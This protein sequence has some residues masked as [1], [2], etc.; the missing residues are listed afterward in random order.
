[1]HGRSNTFAKSSSIRLRKQMTD[2]ER[3]LWYGLRHKQLGVKFRR[4]HA[5]DNYILDFVCLEHKLV[6]EVDGSQHVENVVSDCAR[7]EALQRAGFR[8]LRFF[9][10]EALTTTEAV[11]EKILAELNPPPPQP[12][13]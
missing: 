6:V 8:V 7:T 11:L 13:P 12:S 4:Q 5:F 10:N 9:N 3:K 2:A 1:M